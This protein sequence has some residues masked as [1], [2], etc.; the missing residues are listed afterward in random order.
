MNAISLARVI[1]VS[2]VEENSSLEPWRPPTKFEN[3]VFVES[4]DPIFNFHAKS[5][6]ENEFDVM[7]KRIISIQPNDI[8][9]GLNCEY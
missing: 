2:L 6:I 5:Q 9:K 7:M 1:A 4:F 3:F 8:P